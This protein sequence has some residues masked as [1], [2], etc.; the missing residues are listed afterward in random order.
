MIFGKNKKIEELE[1]EILKLKGKI[2]VLNIKNQN[3]KNDFENKKLDLEANIEKNNKAIS[4]QGN[5][6]HQKDIKIK[7]LENINSNLENENN[8]LKEK[9]D[10]LKSELK[11][12]KNS[13]GGLK[14]SITKKNR[15][16]NQAREIIKRLEKEKK[17]PKKFKHNP[18]L[19]ELKAY[20]NLKSE[21]LINKRRDI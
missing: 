15:K 20:N 21:A 1:S 7:E 4:K 3:L 5:K 17:L 14:S 8:S 16:I 11:L 2:D 19:N 13:N 6:L 9:I 10:S 18:T 12:C